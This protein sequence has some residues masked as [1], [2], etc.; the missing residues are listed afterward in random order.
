MKNSA[1]GVKGEQGGQQ[2]PQPLEGLDDIVRQVY[3][4]VAAI[5]G[6]REEAFRLSREVVR[7]ASTTIKHMHRGEVEEARARLAEAGE[8]VA[9]MLAAVADYPQLRYVGFV[10]DAEKEYAE[11]A[12][13]LAAITREKA[14]GPSDLGIDEIAWLNGLAEVVG[15][16]R[17]H[18]LDLIRGGHAREAEG[19]LAVMEDIYLHTVSFDYPNA[20]TA[21][22]RS[23]TDAARGLVE[24]ARGELTMSL[25]QDELTRRI[26]ALQEELQGDK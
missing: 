5:D 24:R 6:A 3:G 11:A 8:L 23:R 16:L 21:G 17:R 7:A 20:I 1:L 15:E 10:V 4:H 19:Y 2:V 13:V 26:A 12:L 18:I 14:P 25:K 9:Q 22:L